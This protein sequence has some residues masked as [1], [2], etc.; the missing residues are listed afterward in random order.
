MPA[1]FGQGDPSAAGEQQPQPGQQGAPLPFPDRECR[2]CAGAQH[3]LEAYRAMSLRREQQQRQAAGANEKTS[4]QVPASPQE[5]TPVPHKEPCAE[6]HAQQTSPGGRTAE[7]PPDTGQLGRATW[8]F[9][10]T[11]AAYY[12][13]EPTRSQQ[14]LARS[15]VEGLAEFYPC[16]FCRAHLQEQVCARRTSCLA[17]HVQHGGQHAER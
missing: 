4:P 6:Q 16:H 1:L 8:T 17:R 10:H 9:L 3:M 7:C 5:R 13:E 12:P 14:S 2:A 11:W 15:M